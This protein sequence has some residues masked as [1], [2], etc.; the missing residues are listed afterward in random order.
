MGQEA[1]DELI[2]REH[3]ALLPVGA[4]TATVLQEGDAALVEGDQPTV[5]DRHP[6]GLARQV[7]EHAS[8]PAKGTLA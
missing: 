4:V 3:H 8:G 5:R 7:A 1:A 6:V 2:S